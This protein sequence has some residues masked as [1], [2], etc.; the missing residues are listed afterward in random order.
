MLLYSLRIY[1]GTLQLA[2]STIGRI[3][4]RSDSVRS[5]V[6]ASRRYQRWVGKV[7][8][9]ARRHARCTFVYTGVAR[10]SGRAQLA[11]YLSPRDECE[12]CTVPTASH[13]SAAR[14]TRLRLCFFVKCAS[15][16]VRGA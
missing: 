8:E 1:V 3:N 5:F 7:R 16:S 2:P 14:A 9:N 15:F 6:R 10:M 4:S 12:G 11:S 13:C